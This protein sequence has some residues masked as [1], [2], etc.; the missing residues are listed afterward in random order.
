M[1][2]N[3]PVIK[4][5]NDNLDYIILDYVGGPTCCQVWQQAP[6]AIGT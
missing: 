4:D 2:L 6:Q 5:L 3:L 1:L